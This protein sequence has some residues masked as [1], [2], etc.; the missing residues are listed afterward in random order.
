[1]AHTHTLTHSGKK[2]K[3]ACRMETGKIVEIFVNLQDD[4]L[5]PLLFFNGDEPMNRQNLTQEDRNDNVW[6]GE[7]ATPNGKYANYA[8]F[9]SKWNMKAVN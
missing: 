9:N 8:S 5:L 6:D 7:E 2:V 4:I 1:M 3:E